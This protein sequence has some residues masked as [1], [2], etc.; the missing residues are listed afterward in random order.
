M[1]R[2]QFPEHLQAVRELAPQMVALMEQ[3]HPDWYASFYLQEQTS[4]DLRSDTR[5]NG[6]TK[7]FIAGA[8]LRIYDGDTFYESA[9]NDLSLESLLDAAAELVDKVEKNTRGNAVRPYSPPSWADRDLA[10]LDQEIRDQLPADLTPDTEVHFGVRYDVNAFEKGA[11]E[12]LEVAAKKKGRVEALAGEHGIELSMVSSTLGL[13]QRVSLFVDRAVN[14]SQTLF[15]TSASV[16]P[17]KGDDYL[18]E[19]IGGLGGLEIA[20][21]MKDEELLSMLKV[22]DKMESAELL[23]PGVYTIITGPD[24]TGVLAHEAFGHSQE[25]DTWARGRSI[26]R[27]L[28]RT[29]TPV[30]NGLATIYNNP[31]MYTNGVLPFGAWGSYFFDEEGWLAQEQAILEK[32]ILQLPMTNLSSALRLG[33]PRTANGKRENWKHADYVRQTNTYFEAG[34]KTLTDLISQVEY[35]FLATAAAGGMEDPKAMGIQVGIK[36]LE[37]IREGKLTGRIF[38]GPAGGSIQMTGYVPDLLNNIVDRSKIAYW[39]E[40]PDTAALPENKVGGCG[41]YHKELVAAGCGGP[42]L[43]LKGVLLG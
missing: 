18:W 35:G 31:A 33:V 34:E 7:G 40:E 17:M 23:E 4:L 14:M 39:T 12:L 1:M 6:V 30:G 28:H 42:C 16:F 2:A 20:G 8:R 36:Y 11:A 37:E 43:L 21:Y 22:L 9:T 38:K 15:K 3:N 5:Q 27:D 24:V 10:S 32:G 13:T 41:K 26:A 29:K 19:Q 25:G